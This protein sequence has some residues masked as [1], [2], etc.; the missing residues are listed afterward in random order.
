MERES[1]E[2]QETAS[3][4]ND[5]FV[6]IKVDREERP[7]LDSVYMKAVQ[8]STG[9]GGWPLTAFLL[10]DGRF[11]Y[12][13]TYF[14][15][16][17]RFGMPSFQQVLT[18]VLDAY[19][20]RRE[21]VEA[22]S[23]R[24]LEALR[25]PTRG[26][27]QPPGNR[28]ESPGDDSEEREERVEGFQHHGASASLSSRE[29]RDGLRRAARILGR[30][31]DPA[32]GGFGPAPK[33]PQ[34]TTLELLL[35]HHQLTGETESLDMVLTTLRAMARGGIRDHLGGGFHRYSVDDRWLVP[36][37]EKM[38]Y[39]N[40]LLA[41]VYLQA[42][43]VTGDS[44]LKETAETT[45]DYLLADLRHPRGGFFS[46][47]DA[48]SEGE[49]GTFYL[50]TVPEIVETLGEELGH[51]FIAAY[52][53][54]EAGNFEGRNILHL[55]MDLESLAVERG[56]D[57]RKLRTELERAVSLL[58]EARRL[59]EAPFRDE[60]VL[61]SW[62][63]FVLTALAE[64]GA[65]QNRSDYLAAAERNAEFLLEELVQEGLLYRSWKDG[66]HRVPAFLEDHAGLG[67]ALLT[68]HE[69]TLNPRW[70]LEARVMGDRILERFWDEA[71]GLL[72][73]SPND[74]EALVVRPRD[75]MDNA[76]PSGNSLAVELLLRLHGAFG[77]EEYRRIAEMVLAREL[78][79]ATELPS[80]FGRLL[81]AAFRAQEPPTEIVLLGPSGH[82]DLGSLLHAA[83]DLFLPNRVLVG[84]SPG[85]I[86]ALPIL[87]GRD[88][89]GG[90]PTAY[91]C[92]DFSCSLP[93]HDP[94]S[95]VRELKAKSSEGSPGT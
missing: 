2:D 32:R 48:D 22:G 49:E 95:L 56:L 63:S 28:R 29:I 25:A 40:G 21:E 11:F 9:R 94:E 13:G 23:T 57:S 68:L 20:N 59:R 67:N 14:P 69:A 60:K 90:R 38:L 3:L 54:T 74:G 16:E 43:Q 52:G 42:F 34:P 47:R 62:N 82:P 6:N 36:H 77:T 19:R 26:L 75:P 92:R 4:M 18:A 15:P 61:V 46:A 73:D 44:E 39:D 7:D 50:W 80:A 88:L 45:L 87:E 79:M 10:P 83:H 27:R 76:T 84:G 66:R 93:L 35:N 72:Y 64:A 81:S 78:P 5:G 12:G 1:F 53:V 37:F 33:F 89:E 58:F 30:R 41:R 85:E 91:V 70:L 24:L 31:F 55:P 71:D 8:A 86:P 51:L 17:P 65:A